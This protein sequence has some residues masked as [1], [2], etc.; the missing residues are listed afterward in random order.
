MILDPGTPVSL[1]GRPWL[2]KYLAEF[3][4]KI[5][6][7]SA[8]FKVFR[9]GG[10]DKKHESKLLIELLLIMISDKGKEE[11]FIVKV[12]VLDAD[13]T[14]FIGRATLKKWGSILNKRRNVLD[15]EIDGC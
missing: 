12:Y 1:V 9:F 3:D 2:S 14:F 7:S 10:I 13:V 4:S 8:C 15:T 5:E 11:V 6:E